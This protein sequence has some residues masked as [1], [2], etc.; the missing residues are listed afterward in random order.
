M[1]C[2][3]FRPLRTFSAKLWVCQSRPW[4]TGAHIPESSVC[5]GQGRRSSTI[6]G[7]D[8]LITTELH[9]LDQVGELVSRD[10]NSRL[11]LAEEGDDGLS[12]VATDDGDGQ[13]LGVRLAHDLGDEGLGTNDIEGGDTEQALGVKD[14]L[15]LEDL[16]GDRDSGVDGVGDDENVG[17][18]GNLGDGLDEAL[19]DAGVDVEEVITGHSGFAYSS[20]Q[21]L[22]PPLSV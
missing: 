5:H 17:F 3:P 7:L 12:R 21:P 22:P 4:E 2:S 1:P 19:D 8:N 10:V 14:S 16:G 9:T 6:L 11:G 20:R 18:G 15:G 13:A